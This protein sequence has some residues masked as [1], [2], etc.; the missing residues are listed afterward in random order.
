MTV[1]YLQEQADR[2]ERLAR[3]VLDTLACE[4]LMKYARE[5][6]E[7]AN[8]TAPFATAPLIGP[9]RSPLMCSDTSDRPR[10]SALA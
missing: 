10:P 6:R 1:R 3:G 2:A 9:E 8:A 5:C 7:R 4:A